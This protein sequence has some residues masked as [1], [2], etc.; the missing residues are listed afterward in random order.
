MPSSARRR[1]DSRSRSRKHCRCCIERL[2][3]RALLSFGSAA[4]DA[5]WR[6]DGMAG[7]LP[8]AEVLPGA[9]TSVAA[10]S[11][12]TIA[13][14]TMPLA[15]LSAIPPLSSLPGAPVSLYLDFDG[16]VQGQWGEY[17]NIATPAFDQDG[18]PTTFSSAE[19]AAIRQIWQNVAEDYAPF[20]V[21]VTT[22]PPA[23]MAPGST[24]HVVIGG[25][26]G[27]TGAAYGGMAF[28]GG[29]LTDANTVFV[30]SANLNN[31]NA[32][33]T[34]DSVSHE[35]GHGFGLNHQSVYNADGTKTQEYATGSG[36][37]RAP[38][39]GNC[40]AAERGVWWSGP[41]T[42]AADNQD[43]L[44]VLSGVLGYRPDDH[45]NDAEH[46]TALTVEGNVVRG[47]GLIATTTD[48]D[49]FSFDTDAGQISLTA[50]P[51]ESGGNLDVRL[52][53]RDAL[54][55]LLVAADPPDSLSA[56]ITIAVVGGS[57]RLVV[58]SHGAYGDV[59]QYSIHGTIVRAA[60]LLLA[61]SGLEAVASGLQ[62]SLAWT[63]N[64]ANE[65][66]YIVLRSTDSLTWS[67]AATAPANAT[68]WI[69]AGLAAGTT[70]Y[71]EVQATSATTTSEPSNQADAT[72]MP[73]IP[74]GLSA[75]PMSTSRIDL[76]WND[77]AGESGYTIERST[78]GGAY[79]TQIAT[80]A[81]G[82]TQYQDTGLAAATWYQYRVRA[83]NAAGAAPAGP[84]AS[85]ATAA[86]APTPPTA[87]SKLTAVA[88]SSRQVTLRW[89]DNSGN[90]VGF[91]I[92]RSGNAGKTWG[93]VARTGP[94]ATTFSDTSVL[95]R[96]AYRYRVRAFTQTGASDYASAAVTTP[97]R[98]VV[99][100]PTP[101]GLR[102]AVVSSQEVSL[103]WTDN[104]RTELGYVVERSSNNG[105]TWTKIAQTATNVSTFTDLRVSAI[106]NYRYRVRAI[107]EVGVSGY[108][109]VRTATPAVPAVAKTL[110]EGYA[111]YVDA[112]HAT[113]VENTVFPGLFP[114]LT[115]SPKLP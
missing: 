59:G 66:G 81:A 44:S 41:S 45:G 113:T 84:V 67:T 115:A 6:V 58:A 35:S 42:A 5:A 107:N 70:Y 13:L 79:W 98:P 31:G 96:T 23:N 10:S 36:D 14:P 111:S 3:P 103:R 46:A 22:V 40:F 114:L 94:N 27:W 68:A 106:Q 92:E 51:L 2:E 21:N 29:F 109:I 97:V 83:W 57:Y 61:P 76:A 82:V 16:D 75:T 7:P 34:A 25:S 12:G 49:Y 4:W 101:T 62:I 20:H 72:T 39:M 102:T 48:V 9:T 32:R 64:A 56:T 37:G 90:E 108:M 85:A 43:D 15:P 11:G 80:V 99:R 93:A 26:G 19:L 71:Y 110:M 73:A 60:G 86:P 55:N 53:L 74:G 52:E 30:F 54:G 88:E 91:L 112:Y 50:A 105:K 63:D 69:D 89:T 8:V 77:V 28:V 18:D 104:A 47:S 38:L 33:Y 1:E 95:A 100:P 65:T 24:L 17:R 78:N 87:P